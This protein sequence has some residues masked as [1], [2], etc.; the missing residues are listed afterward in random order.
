MRGRVTEVRAGHWATTTIIE[1]TGFAGYKFSLHY[2]LEQ[3]VA[4]RVVLCDLRSNRNP[5]SKWPDNQ[6]ADITHVS[7]FTLLA[8]HWH[9]TKNTYMWETQ[10]LPQAHP[11]VPTLLQASPATAVQ[12][13]VGGFMTEAYPI[14]TANVGK[15][16]QLPNAWPL[17]CWTRGTQE[18]RASVKPPV[19]CVLM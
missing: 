16:G 3:L 18:N 9:C 5:G 17:R 8:F 7:L 10:K 6:R 2:T 12:A 4:A 11:H 15:A 1:K 19:T 14:C 13:G